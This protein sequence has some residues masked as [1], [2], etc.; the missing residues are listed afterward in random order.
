MAYPSPLSDQSSAITLRVLNS[1]YGPLSST[2]V[3]TGSPRA[4]CISSLDST[5]LRSFPAVPIRPAQ[6][7]EDT[8]TAERNRLAS[9]IGQPSALSVGGSGPPRVDSRAAGRRSSPVSRA[10]HRT[11]EPSAPV[12]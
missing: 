12:V 9:R 11:R 8:T 6:P 5:P 10:P 3:A 2:P 1:S 4:P 7:Q